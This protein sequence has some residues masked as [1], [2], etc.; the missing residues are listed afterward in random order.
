M[1]TTQAKTLVA[2]KCVQEAKAEGPHE[3]T[4]TELASEY[5]TACKNYPAAMKVGH[6]LYAIARVG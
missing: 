3:T 1:N 6:I 2:R 4:G 5:E